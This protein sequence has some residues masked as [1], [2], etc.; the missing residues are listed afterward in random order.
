[1]KIWKLLA[2]APALLLWAATSVLPSHAAELAGPSSPAQPSTCA[3]M[4]APIL[5]A[6]APL[7]SLVLSPMGEPLT[8]AT[9]VCA[10]GDADCIGKPLNSRC[11]IGVKLCQEISTCSAAATSPRCLCT[12]PP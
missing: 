4:T 5:A 3:A 12:S 9:L 6:P 2:A 8:A 7:L 11:G 1:M 10:C